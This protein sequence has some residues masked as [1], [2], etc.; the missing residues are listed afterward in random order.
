MEFFDR[1]EEVM[2]IELTQYGKHLLSIGKFKPDQ[3]AFFDD[4]VLYD[5]RY[6]PSGSNDMY[7]SKDKRFVKEKRNNTE[8]RI[9]ET[10][11]LK[12]QY[13]FSSREKSGRPA[14]AQADYQTDCGPNFI[15]ADLGEHLQDR[16]HEKYGKPPAP[17]FGLLTGAT[18]EE[19]AWKEWSVIDATDNYITNLYDIV[20]SDKRTELGFAL[21]EM[22]QYSQER[23]NF[24]LYSAFTSMYDCLYQK[25]LGDVKYYPYVFPLGNSSLSS[26]YAPAWSVNFLN[27]KLLN[28]DLYKT[29]T[30]YT[31][32]NFSSMKIPQLETRIQ[33]DTYITKMT[34]DL[35]YVQNYASDNVAFEGNELDSGKFM[36]DTVF[37]V[38]TDYLLLEV[39]ELNTDFIKDNFEIEVFKVTE[40]VDKTAA[41]VV[42]EV[43][44]ASAVTNLDS[45]KFSDI[46]GNV[47]EGKIDTSI[48][49]ADS[50]Y[51]RIGTQDVFSDEEYLAIAIKNSIEAWAER[52][53]EENSGTW[54][55]ATVNVTVARNF[56][57]VG[58][59]DCGDGTRLTITQKSG[60]E[61]NVKIEGS[62]ADS[63]AIIIQNNKGTDEFGLDTYGQRKVE[64]FIGGKSTVNRDMEQLYFYDP[65]KEEDIGTYHVDYYFDL[66]VDEEISSKYYCR[67]KRVDKKQ[68]IMADQQIPFNCDEFAAAKPEN[69]YKIE[70]TPEDFEEPC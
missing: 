45:L 12:V 11:R 58:C 55:T 48:N 27:G 44:D 25:S 42:I 1:K 56:S 68:S 33:Y 5:I 47:Y 63:A 30:F 67:S 16:I 9:K 65:R 51:S 18:E 3:Y 34:D 62:L 32:S 69:I 6:I 36:D 31:G 20:N 19:I 10:P 24:G 40:T 57:G 60:K 38:K 39:D 4:D 15:T 35:T 61:G 13:N 70:V 2:D 52:I 26:K 50:T 22:L 14:I 59:T 43:V 21:K 23:N 54:Y 17:A 28:E 37:Q 8:T 53:R 66:L 64:S 49:F 29:K 41:S 7:D 46:Q